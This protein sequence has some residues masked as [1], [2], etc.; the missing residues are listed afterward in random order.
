MS[1]KVIEL[2]DRAIGVGDDSGKRLL[3]P[4]FA[5]VD[6]EQLMLGEQAEKQARLRPTDSFNKFWHELNLEQIK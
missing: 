3:S 1:L 6:A 4:G 2:N 5:L